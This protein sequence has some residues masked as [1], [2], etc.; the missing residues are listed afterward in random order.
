M[1]KV[2]FI[3]QNASVTLA[4]GAWDKNDFPTNMKP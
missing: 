2:V 4:R 1:P 3:D